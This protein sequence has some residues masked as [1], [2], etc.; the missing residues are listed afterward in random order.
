MEEQT[1]ISYEHHDDNFIKTWFIK[2]V[3]T[4]FEL[5][6]HVLIGLYELLSSPLVEIEQIF[7]GW[8]T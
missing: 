1:S 3:Y 5:Y 7:G 8:D 6:Q 2:I 4:N